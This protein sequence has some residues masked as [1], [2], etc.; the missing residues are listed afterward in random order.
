MPREG[1]LRYFF[2]RKPWEDMGSKEENYGNSALY[3][4][5]PFV[6]LLAGFERT[7]KRMSNSD[8]FRIFEVGMKCWA[9]C[10]GALC[11]YRYSQKKSSVYPVNHI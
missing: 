3:S 5:I 1:R 10:W 9:P 11:I 2:S 4:I 6:L 7:T 8:V